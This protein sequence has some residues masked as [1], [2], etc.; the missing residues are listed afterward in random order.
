MVIKNNV[1]LKK[2]ILKRVNK[3]IS[4]TRFYISEV[5]Q[6][7]IDK[8]YDDYEPRHYERTYKLMLD[9]ILIA[10]VVQTS[11]GVSVRIGVDEDYLNY[12]Y[13]GGATG[14]DVFS[15]ASGSKGMEHIH[16][17]TVPG[18]VRIWP[19]AMEEL[20]GKDGILRLFKQ[21]LRKCGVPVV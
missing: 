14:E 1:Q 6:K 17:Y 10:D 20:G 4:Q 18:N 9:S 5:L 8:Y 15:W 19:D 2:E 16:G 12:K 21:N 7:Y 13:K 3:A 11:K